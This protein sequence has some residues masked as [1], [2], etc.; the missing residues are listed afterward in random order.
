MGEGGGRRTST[1]AIDN[2]TFRNNLTYHNEYG[3]IDADGQGF[4]TTALSADVNSYTWTHNALANRDGWRTYPGVNWYPSASEHQAQF[5]TDYTLVS[6][7]W[8]RRA[9]SDGRDLGRIFPPRCTHRSEN[10]FGPSAAIPLVTAPA[11]VPGYRP[12]M[13]EADRTGAVASADDCP[14][15]GQATQACKP[16]APQEGRQVQRDCMSIEWGTCDGLS[17]LLASAAAIAEL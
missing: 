16:A 13:G 7:S 1:F 3:V 2:L 8:Y 6:T 5:N 10:Q 4:G 11:L 15:P 14:A 9:A 17:Q 12:S